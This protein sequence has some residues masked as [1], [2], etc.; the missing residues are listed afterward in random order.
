MLFVTP[1]MS[2]VAYGSSDE[3]SNASDA[4]ENQTAT[5][6]SKEDEM[7]DVTL[8]KEEVEPSEAFSLPT[9]KQAKDASS[10]GRKTGLASLLPEPKNV[11]TFGRE[12]TGLQDDSLASKPRSYVEA[13]SGEDEEILEIEEDYEPILKRAKKTNSS[14]GD[15]K[16]RTVS[17]GSLFSLLPAP[18]QAENTWEKQD[19]GG[20]S[21]SSGKKL[22]AEDKK[23]K[24]PI[25]IAIPTAP[26]TDSDD[27][28]DI[29]G[30]KKV[31]APSKGGSGLKSLLP[32]PKHSITQKADNPNKP[33]VKL[34]SRPLVPHTLTKK[35]R[36][37]VKKVQKA[38]KN[39]KEDD[40]VSD[41]DDEP[42]SSFFTF[43]EKPDNE[44]ITS[45][46]L[47]AVSSCDKLIQSNKEV[48]SFPVEL[49]MNDNVSS[50]C[51]NASMTQS[52]EITQ[53][54]AIQEPQMQADYGRVGQVDVDENLEARTYYY[55]EQK[56]EQNQQYGSYPVSYHANYNYGT[57]APAV[58][59]SYFNQGIESYTYTYPAGSAQ[60]TQHEPQEEDIDLE[61]LQ[62][63]TGR[64]NRR[65]EI[66][67]V[68]VNADEQV[69]NAAEMVVKYGTEEETHRPSRKKK[70][71]PTAQQRRKH[72]ISYLAFQAKE[73]EFEL[74]QQWAANRQTRR[75]TQSKYGF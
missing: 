28:D 14:E 63:L 66:N 21:T 74:R 15:D 67:I 69:G 59:E 34:A 8:V 43:S 60:R 24:Q 32:K 5:V 1:S 7:K 38:A 72:Q 20:K 30:A 46:D 18:W 48:Q 2:L 75:Q 29:P 16:L 25:K 41:G 33:S 10:L 51:Q 19:E 54:A 64:R 45:S 40:Q 44:N 71:M 73:R 49:T 37:P 52:S 58:G 62:K 56:L 9:P 6:S 17:V 61:K 22:R 36:A 65:E 23:T 53:S 39:D 3:E 4:E 47:T 11:N 70:D 42:V 31:I 35:A 68:D 57:G 13:I 27:E 12:S 26:K 55:G 50:T